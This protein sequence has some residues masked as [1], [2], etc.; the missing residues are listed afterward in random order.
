MEQEVEGDERTPVQSVI[1]ADT[2]RTALLKEQH[3]LDEFLKNVKVNADD[4]EEWDEAKDEE[5]NRKRE[6]LQEVRCLLGFRPCN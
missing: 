4:E 3:E 2:E 5:I 6:R 1:E